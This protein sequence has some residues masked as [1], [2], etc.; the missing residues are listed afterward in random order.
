M[1]LPNAHAAP[2]L[3]IPMHSR[4]SFMLVLGLK[5]AREKPLQ[6]LVYARALSDLF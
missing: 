4:I 6:N 2:P 5:V 3:I 1:Q